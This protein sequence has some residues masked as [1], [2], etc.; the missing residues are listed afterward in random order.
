[1]FAAVLALPAWL[2]VGWAAF[3]GTAT[4]FL[5]IA[6]ASPLVAAAALSLALVVSLRP[7]VRATRRPDAIDAAFS[8]LFTGLV[9]AAGVGTEAT[10]WLAVAAAGVTVAGLAVN[11]R[12]L[13]VEVRERMR[14]TMA[15]FG[16]PTPPSSHEPPRLP[17]IDGGEYIVVTPR[18]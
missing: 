11:G 16:M 10:P 14:V 17:P 5:A 7:S 1:M 6:I 9:V 4:G 12:R 8:L 13:S 15:A 18:S 2:F 3:S